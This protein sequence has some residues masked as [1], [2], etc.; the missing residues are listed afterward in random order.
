MPD[1]RTRVR[2]AEVMDDPTLDRRE[3]ERAL[4]ALSRVNRVSGT[5]GRVTRVLSRIPGGR[6]PRVLDVG[7]GGGDV[8]IRVARWAAREGRP[9]ELVGLDRSAV[10][11]EHARRGAGRAGVDVA[12]VEADAVAAFPPGPWDLVVIN[13]F[14][15]HLPD[16]D[17]VALLQEVRRNAH[18]LLAQDLERGPVGY[19]TAWFG[20]RLLSRS[21]VG[22]VDGPLS[23]RAGFRPRELL[24]LARRA[25]LDAARVRRSWPSRLVLSW[26]G[27]S[28]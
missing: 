11:L 27:E 25:G 23:V 10:A 18:R 20:M 14:L 16:A 17:V 24:A 28:R 4:V 8:L 9:V 3:H 26:Q 1:L 15:H 13:L 12:F 21:R 2:E 7:C 6:A 5:A 19:L 22:H